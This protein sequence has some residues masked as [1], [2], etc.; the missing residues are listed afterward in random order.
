M[1]LAGYGLEAKPDA[2][3][4]RIGS[5]HESD[6]A[7][8]AEPA[9]QVTAAVPTET[10]SQAQPAQNVQAPVI[11]KPVEKGEPNKAEKAARQRYAE[12][13]AK[14]IAAARVRQRI[15]PQQT[16]ERGIM[17]FGAEEPRTGFFGNKN[18]SLDTLLHWTSR[19]KSPERIS[20]SKQARA[21]SYL[22]LAVP[23][24]D[25]PY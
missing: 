18:R 1:R 2:C 13:K 20:P 3:K 12:R 16:Q 17:A 15:E 5:R 6:L 24:V 25:P 22:P 14:R 9:L 23:G 7:A 8:S 4:L 19:R 11:E 10:Q 21:F